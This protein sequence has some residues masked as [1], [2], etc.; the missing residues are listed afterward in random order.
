M[1]LKTDSKQYRLAVHTSTIN[2]IV[3]LLYMY[4]VLVV[5]I[6]NSTYCRTRSTYVRV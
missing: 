5:L 4:A 1:L 6:V 3:L 2:I